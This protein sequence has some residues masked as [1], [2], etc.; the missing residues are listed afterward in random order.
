MAPAM[1]GS[2][3]P[4]GDFG[5]R[6]KRAREA[7][8]MSLR[9]IA[10][11]TKISVGALEALERNDLTR[12]PGG[13]FL[14]AFV[15]A[16]AVEVGVDPE[17]TVREFLSQFPHES[18]TAGS[19]HYRVV[20]D[21]VTDPGR[22]RARVVI[23]MAAVALPVVLLASYFLI[24]RPLWTRFAS[25]GFAEAAVEES[26][27]LESTLTEPLTFEVITR[28][29][30]TLQVVLDG[31]PR[32]ARRMTAGER[33]V[34]RAQRELTFT[35]SDAGAIQLSINSQPTV[36]L[37]RSGQRRTVQIDRRNYVSFLASQ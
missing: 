25:P 17:Q 5:A 22:M 35:T 3:R 1:T 14:R 4:G 33:L 15:R 34:L 24:V 20:D 2:D 28:A 6:M 10:E 18:F 8:G 37:G 36:S 32:E 27:A 21:L 29:P 11:S 31:A 19:P 12:L 26:S 7:S 16:Y 30:L 9:Q 13:I 23:G